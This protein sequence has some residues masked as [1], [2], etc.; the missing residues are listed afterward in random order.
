MCGKVR[1]NYL[2]EIAE[3]ISNVQIPRFNKI[4]AKQ[5]LISFKHPSWN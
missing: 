3:N 1:W 4:L 2:I 5:L